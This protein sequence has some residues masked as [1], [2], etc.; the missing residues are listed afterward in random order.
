MTVLAIVAAGLAAA[1]LVPSGARRPQG[2][3]RSSLPRLP[4]VLGAAALPGGALLAFAQGTTLVLGLFG[5]ATAWAAAH[6]V[7][8]VRER[9]VVEGRRAM[10]VELC[11]TL[12]AELRAG[13]PPVAALARCVDVWPQFETVAVA[14]TLGADVP[15][16]LRRLADTP[17]AAGLR[18]V[19]GA[20]QV[21]E[22]AG[23]GLSVA[24]D[25][26]AASAR[27]EHR[28]LMLVAA[29]LASAQATARLVAALPVLALLMGTGI[30]GDPWG[31]LLDT[32]FGLVC[33][34]C[35]LALIIAGLT[36]LERI[37]AG[38]TSR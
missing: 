17:G 21:S 25:R 7:R 19:A 38:V 35:G 23:S 6:L 27:H 26:V 3:R 2:W 11:H 14:A 4:L 8:Q 29:E 32:P 5:L 28:T 20:W 12:A 37:A 34:G 15:T 36:W 33:L 30:G 9:K 1:L 24:L 16:A 13:R 18:D 22:A 31:F 10:V